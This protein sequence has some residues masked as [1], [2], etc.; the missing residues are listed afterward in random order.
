MNTLKMKDWGLGFGEHV[1]IAG[2]CSVETEKQ[3]D[4]LCDS[5][6]KEPQIGMFRGGVWK[7]R[8]RP[9]NFEGLGEEALPLLQKVKNRLKIPVCVEVANT[10]HVEAAL[11]HGIDVLWI[12]ARTTVNPFSVQEIADSLKGVD[13]PLMVKN[14]IN[15]DLA[16]WMGALERMNGVGIKKLAAIHRGFADPYD[17]IYRNKP[18]WN[19]AMQLKLELPEI[20]IINDPSHIAGKSEMVQAVAQR[21]LNF[22]MDGLMIETHPHPKKAWSDARQQLNPTELFNLIKGISFRGRIDFENQ[23]P[24][25]LKEMR[26]SI[27]H[28]D[29]KLIDLLSDRFHLID[30]VGAY[31]KA[32]KLSVYQSGRWKDV[33]DS[34]IKLGVEKN[35][36]EKFMKSLMISIHD[37]SIKRQ[38]RQ[39]ANKDTEPLKI[40]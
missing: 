12:G 30:Q 34:R 28:I 3:I 7:P 31:K 26:D 39:I 17:K 36:S 15:P 35:M 10:T 25:N 24:E 18:N 5:F 1:I 32:H 11:K 23:I 13:I 2:P 40:I 16:L 19:L 9:G 29:Q 33:T 38:E 21:A 27:D 14:P 4:D 8:T 22:G 6:E 37:E 20:E